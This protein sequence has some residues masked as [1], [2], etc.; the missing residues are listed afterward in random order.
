M[1]KSGLSQSLPASFPNS[2]TERRKRGIMLVRTLDESLSSSYEETSLRRRVSMSFDSNSSEDFDTSRS[3]SVKFKDISI[4]EYDVALGDNPSCRG[5][6]PVSLGWKYA[7]VESSLC[8]EQFEQVRTNSRR[9]NAQLRMPASYRQSLLT[10]EWDVPVSSILRTIIDTNV[11]RKQRQITA[12]KGRKILLREEKIKEAGR[13]LK[14]L[15]RRRRRGDK[16]KMTREYC[17]DSDVSDNCSMDDSLPC[18]H[19]TGSIDS[20]DS[21]SDTFES[22]CSDENTSRPQFVGIPQFPARQA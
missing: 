11:V 9:S 18:L 16:K 13:L 12:S 3:L 1:T 10:E 20:L 22:N 2:Q 14:K 15:F 6:A 21:I 7:E 5:G 19:D 8:I 17:K 4:R